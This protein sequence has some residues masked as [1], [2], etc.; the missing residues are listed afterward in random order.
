MRISCSPP[1]GYEIGLTARK[2]TAHSLKSMRQIKAERQRIDENIAAPLP[3][4]NEILEACGTAR[5]NKGLQEIEL[6]KRPH[7]P[8]SACPVDEDR[9]DLRISVYTC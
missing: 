8:M 2:D 5:A 4:L 1:L 7:L 3:A 6:L 9:P